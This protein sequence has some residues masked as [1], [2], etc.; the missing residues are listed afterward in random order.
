MQEA[1]LRHFR[2]SSPLRRRG[3]GAWDWKFQAALSSPRFHDVHAQQDAH[4]RGE[5]EVEGHVGGNDVP[6]LSFHAVRQQSCA[7]LRKRI[8]DPKPAVEDSTP[9][10]D[11]KLEEG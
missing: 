7:P 4:S 9:F 8:R 5:P 11:S 6:D 1:L 3:L 2:L 10:E